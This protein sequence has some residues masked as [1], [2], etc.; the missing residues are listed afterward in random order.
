MIDECNRQDIQIERQTVKSRHT[1][2]DIYKE[3]CR[4]TLWN[5]LVMS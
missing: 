5:L 4:Y 1:N 3:T 2:E